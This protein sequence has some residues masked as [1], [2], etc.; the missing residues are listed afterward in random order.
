MVDAT[1]AELA[2]F[3]P[4]SLVVGEVVDLLV[5][6]WP[7]GPFVRGGCSFLPPGGH[8]PDRRA[9][10]APVDGRLFFAG[11]ATHYA[12]EPAT[13]HGAIETGYRAADEVLRSLREVPT[14]EPSPGE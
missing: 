4:A 9:L 10:A 1:L 14:P 2:S 5:Q 13:R 8:S 3:L 11:E 6:R 7:R 12:S